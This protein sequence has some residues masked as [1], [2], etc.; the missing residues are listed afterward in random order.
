MKDQN[1]NR[2]KYSYS[3]NNVRRT[4][5]FIQYIV[6]QCRN[7]TQDICVVQYIFNIQHYSYNQQNKIIR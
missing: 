2:Y 4:V 7:S 6:K 5:H 1:Y 3:Q